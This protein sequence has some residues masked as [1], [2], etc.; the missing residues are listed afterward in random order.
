L[1]EKGFRKITTP[2]KRPFFLTGESD[3]YCFVLNEP[4]SHFDPDGLKVQVCCRAVNDT[5]IA[6]CLATICGKKHC[7]IK[8]DTMAAGM[9]PATPANPGKLPTCPCGKS[10]AIVDETFEIG[11][12]CSDIQGADESCVNNELTIGKSLGNWGPNNNCNTFAGNIIK[13]CGGKSICLNWGW[14]LHWHSPYDEEY[15]YECT[16]WLY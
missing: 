5:P 10:T 13:K 2:S 9:G 11:A 1:R 7:W 12:T 15:V 4:L 3:L 6:N 14:V 8:T 16:Q